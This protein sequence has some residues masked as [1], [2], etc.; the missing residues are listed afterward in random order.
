VKISLKVF[1]SSKSLPPSTRTMMAQLPPSAGR[2]G[3]KL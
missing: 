3:G 1:S 2:T